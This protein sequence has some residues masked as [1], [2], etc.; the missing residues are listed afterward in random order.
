M[1]EQGQ[2]LY[3]SVPKERH[4][5]TARAA[6][7]A[8]VGIPL[9]DDH[10][11]KIAAGLLVPR[12]KDGV[13]IP[14]PY[15]KFGL[16]RVCD[17]LVH[18]ADEKVMAEA[19]RACVGEWTTENPNTG[20]YPP[21]T[22]ARGKSGR[23]SDFLALSY[24]LYVRHVVHGEEIGDRDKG[25]GLSY[26]FNLSRHAIIE[27]IKVFRECWPPDDRGGKYLTRKIAIFQWVD[28]QSSSFPKVQKTKTKLAIAQAFLKKKLTTVGVR[29]TQI[30]A[31]AIAQG[32]AERTLRDAFTVGRE[33]GEYKAYQQG[34]AW[35]WRKLRARKASPSDNKL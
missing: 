11:M 7:V 10:K 16:C 3:R 15:G 29:S 34:K 13:L 21:L 9:I 12:M 14:G 6:A 2:R 23:D 28:P 22:S 31:T 1:V 27:R 17:K 8:R 24:G 35:Y 4:L 5:E 33:A 30:I 26:E 19:H 32:I 18:C 20:N 25:T